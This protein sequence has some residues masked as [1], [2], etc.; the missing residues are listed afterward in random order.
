METMMAAW[1]AQDETTIHYEVSDDGLQRETLL[2]LPGLLGAI[3]SQWQTFIAPLA[4][5]YRV[6]RVDLRGHGRS[7]NKATHLTVDQMVE[8]IS[9][10]LDYLG[11][12]ALHV[13]GYDLGGYLGLLLALREPRRVMTL[14]LHATKFYWTDDAVAA[15]RPQLDPDVIAERVPHYADQLMQAHGSRWRPLVRQG[16][17]LIGQLRHEGLTEGMVRRAQLPALVSVGD[18]DE[19]VPL[20]EALRLSRILPQGGLFVLP[21]VRHPLASVPLVPLLPMMLAFHRVPQR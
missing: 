12:D 8:D 20:P 6:I 21:R 1:R 11:V 3:R 15:M 4:A 18:R 10:L 19:M 13:A 17:D 2:L 5:H 7:Q 14:L 16:A 9:G